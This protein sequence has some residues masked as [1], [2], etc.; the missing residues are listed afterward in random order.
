MCARALRLA[1]PNRSRFMWIQKKLREHGK[2]PM[3]INAKQKKNSKKKHLTGNGNETS[4]AV[5]I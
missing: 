2:L 3:Q 1:S 5:Q 4:I